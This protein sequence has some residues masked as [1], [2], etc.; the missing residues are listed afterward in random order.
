MLTNVIV[1]VSN[2]VRTTSNV[3]DDNNNSGDSFAF[4]ASSSS[5][6][7]I[8][9]YVLGQLWSV[10]A[11]LTCLIAFT[12]MIP[13]L[14]NTCK[15]QV[16]LVNLAISRLSALKWRRGDGGDN[17]DDVADTL[18]MLTSVPPMV[19][20]STAV[21]GQASSS[22]KSA[23]K[24]NRKGNKQQ[25]VES[26][27]TN[28][29][30]VTIGVAILALLPT[31]FN[32]SPYGFAPMESNVG[33]ALPSARA[34]LRTI[35]TYFSYNWVMLLFVVSILVEFVVPALAGVAFTISASEGTLRSITSSSPSSSLSCEK[36]NRL[37]SLRL[38]QFVVSLVSLVASTILLFLT[39]L[40]L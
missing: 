3:S 35:N 22:S 23:K 18:V 25:P 1:K 34:F 30:P 7:Y 4:T 2:L 5:S 21:V 29:L 15:K 9:D 12:A 10:V 36:K 28:F 33:A 19:E 39:V 8:S 26:A 17:N 40:Y 32:N 27:P 6:Q 16:G 37:F 13:G 11:Q 24:K 31:F 38:R 14:I 20:T